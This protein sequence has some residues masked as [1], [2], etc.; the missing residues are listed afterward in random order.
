MQYKVLV[1]FSGAISAPANAVI[2]ITDEVMV[3]D[4]LKAG[5]IVPVK[6]SEEPVSTTDDAGDVEEKLTKNS[7]S[8]PKNTDDADGE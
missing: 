5:Y 8:K 4:L 3:K 7:K 1:G 2:T 6:D